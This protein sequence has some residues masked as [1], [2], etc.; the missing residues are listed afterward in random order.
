[1]PYWIVY[2]LPTHLSLPEGQVISRTSEDPSPRLRT[3]EATKEFAE[4]PA[5]NVMWSNAALDFIPIPAPVIIDRVDVDI[6][7][8]VAFAP[9]LLL[10]GRQRNDI[11]ALLERVLGRERFRGDTEGTGI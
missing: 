10:T 3:H 5:D 6:F 4:R 11:R 1:M 8:D 2:A 9:V 7:G